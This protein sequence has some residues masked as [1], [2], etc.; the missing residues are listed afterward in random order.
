MGRIAEILDFTRTVKNG[1]NVSDV[2][3]NPGG[4]ANKTVEDFS[5]P[6]DDSYPLKTDRA[7]LVSNGREGGESAI[8]YGD[9]ISAPVALEG[10]KRIYGRQ[11][12]G[13]TVNQ[14]WLKNDGSIVISNDNATLEISAAGSIKG[15]NSNGFYELQTDGDFNINGVIFDTHFHNQPNDSDGDTEEPTGGPMS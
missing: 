8:A 5:L 3:V 15:S 14:V 13:T 6:G 9:P 7:F 2:R 11:A 12:N 10:D 4:G 1:A